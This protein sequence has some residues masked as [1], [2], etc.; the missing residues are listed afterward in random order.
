MGDHANPGRLRLHAYDAGT[1]VELFTSGDTAPTINGVVYN[2]FVKFVPPT[3]TNGHVYVASGG[4][5]LFFGLKSPVMPVDVTK[6]VRV[7]PGP[8]KV[9]PVS[10]AVTQ[11]FT[12]TNTGKTPIAGPVSL[13]FDSLTPEFSLAL[14]PGTGTTSYTTPTGAF[15]HNFPSLGAKQSQKTEVTFTASADART[16]QTVTYSLRVLA[17]GGAR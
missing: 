4:S 17:G 1:L 2:N 12:L 13:V 16:G 14:M 7:T 10:G 8:Q 9:D 3:V 11:R 15:Y 6:T 5:I